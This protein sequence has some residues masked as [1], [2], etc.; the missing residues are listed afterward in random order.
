MNEKPILF[1]GGM[2][3]A[4][5]DG[6]KTMTRRVVKK[7]AWSPMSQEMFYAGIDL[8][9]REK[10]KFTNCPYGK[11]GDG[12]WVRETWATGWNTMHTQPSKITPGTYVEYKAGPPTLFSSNFYKWRSPI[13][14]PRWASRITLEVISVRVER[15][16]DISEEDAIAEGCSGEPCD[17]PNP[18]M[19]G[20]C[21]DCMNSGYQYPPGLE[22]LDLWDSINAK[23][24]Y[25]WESN[26]WV[27]AVDFKKV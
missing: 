15:V 19:P 7:P 8:G 27:W 9:V 20:A 25:P 1:S 5:L 11:P 4:I 3:R 10:M 18:V 17:H 23:R 14:M 26:P 16:Q 22:F 2:V 13:Y 21:E 6:T 24:G 12:L